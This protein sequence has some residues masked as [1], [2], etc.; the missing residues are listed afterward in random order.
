MSTYY[1]S[2]IRI[3]K[4]VDI[5]L[6]HNNSFHNILRIFS[7]QLTHFCND[8]SFTLNK[9]KIRA[10]RSVDFEEIFRR[11][12]DNMV[13]VSCLLFML[14]AWPLPV[15]VSRWKAG[16]WQ[17]YGPYFC[18]GLMGVAFIGLFWWQ[19]MYASEISG[20]SYW[21]QTEF[22]TYKEVFRWRLPNIYWQHFRNYLLKR[23]ENVSSR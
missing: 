9:K 21:L 12:R 4:F 22:A 7:F 3:Y 5:F 18:S 10:Y 19:I 2:Y 1:R 15:M 11:Y 6:D 23:K 14:A 16:N 20:D 8:K 13:L 17:V